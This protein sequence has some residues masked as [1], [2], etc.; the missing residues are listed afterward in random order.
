MYRQG[1]Q[2]VVG[3]VGAGLSRTLFP[4]AEQAKS[5]REAEKKRNVRGRDMQSRL[6]ATERLRCALNLKK[7]RILS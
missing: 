5:L 4:N 2:Q 1:R 6:R 3:A 7:R